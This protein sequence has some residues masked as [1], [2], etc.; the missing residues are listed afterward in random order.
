MTE[1][2]LTT[3]MPV[4][5]AN[6]DHDDN[7]QTSLKQVYSLENDDFGETDLKQDYELENPTD[8]QDSHIDCAQ[9]MPSSII[10]ISSRQLVQVTADN[11][12]KVYHE[13]LESSSFSDKFV[14]MYRNLP[15]DMFLSQTLSDYHSNETELYNLRNN[16]FN[17]L[18]CCEEFPFAPGSE[19]KKR[20]NTRVGEG[21]AMKLC[22]DIYIL[23]SV[24]DGASFEDMK[25]LLSLLKLCSQNESICVDPSV[26]GETPFVG[27]KKSSSSD[28]E[29]SLLRGIV[30]TIQADTLH[31]KQEN[32]SFRD[33]FINDLEVVRN[34]IKSLK[35]TVSSALD[36]IQKNP[37][38]IAEI[39][40]S[41]DRLIDNK[42]NGVANIKSDIKQIRTDMRVFDEAAEMQ[43]LTINEKLSDIQK[44]EKR[45]LKIES[46]L[47]QS[48]HRSANTF[49]PGNVDTLYNVDIQNPD[50]AGN[51]M[52][53]TK[54]SK[55]SEKPF[56][57]EELTPPSEGYNHA[58]A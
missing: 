41:V 56:T 36:T 57:A 47:S 18:K 33:E 39:I 24:I 2:N 54:T 11:V 43:Y 46:K 22:N 38:S 8:T 23:I 37:E 3:L 52:C 53:E 20:K 10:G 26:G 1:H 6:D 50:L 34:D 12:N 35:S 16:L 40:Q 32:K 4:V 5:L 44:L 17:E 15:K 13:I 9:R 48:K 42:S 29:L 58:H 30:A 7:D 25:D 45:M 31:M 28:V 14:Q 21:E 19:L 49:S 27:S 51:D 55:Q